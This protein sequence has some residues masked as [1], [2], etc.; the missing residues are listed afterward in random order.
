MRHK[1]RQ[2]YSVLTI[3]GRLH[4]RRVRWHC[5]QE[6]S[7]CPSDRWLDDAEATISQGVREMACRLNQ[8]STS[9]ERTA[10]NL[11][12]TAHIELSKETLREV[13]HKDAQTVQRQLQR[14]ELQPQWSA[15]DG[16]TEQGPTRLYLGCDG[17]K[18]PLVTEQEKQKRR[19][20]IRQKRSRSGRKCR[21]LPR[22]KSGADQSYKEFRIAVVHDESQQHR[23]VSVT[24]GNHEA[25]GRMMRRMAVQVNF[26]QA[27]QRV[28]NIDGAPWI[29]NQIEFHG[30]VERGHIGLDYYHLKEN[31]QKARHIV[32]GPPTGE[33]EHSEGG[34]WVH[35]IMHTFYEQGYDAVWEKLIAWRAALRGTKR[36]AADRLIQYVAERRD[37][38]RYPQFRAQGWQIGS[39]PTEAQCKTTT[40]RL[41]GRGR[42]W[43]PDN[44][45]GIMA[46]AALDAS[47]MWQQHWTNLDPQRN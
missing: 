31:V 24:S 47:G 22:R 26:L 33:D 18:V 27:D 7:L 1:G 16:T 3:N 34:R 42:R 4:L 11:S 38:I 30:L 10:A 40:H 35:E 17:V 15:V 25:A 37:M 23:F 32:F 13:V 28:A 20:G 12:H 9:F 2:E 8:D 5:P 29:R 45:E 6:G 14:G 36:Q 39:G 21:P 41:K 44:A 43:D 46:L 19:A